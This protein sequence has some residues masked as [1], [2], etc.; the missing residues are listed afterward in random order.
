MVGYKRTDRVG[1]QIRL[2]VADIL[3]RRLK[4]PRLGFVTLTSVDLT[5]DLRQ[6]WVYVTVLEEGEKGTEAMATLSRAAGFIRGEL[7]RRVKL[8]YVPELTF[9][10]D[11]SVDQ[12]RRVMDLLD[13]LQEP[14]RAAASP[15][16]QEE[17][18]Q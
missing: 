6:A 3:R 4:D 16:A 2:E 1:D 10:R 14:P 11:T 17:V 5:P 8:R 18:G 7:A 12:V 13:E 15:A 9:V